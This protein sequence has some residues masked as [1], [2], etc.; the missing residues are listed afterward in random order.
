MFLFQ[1]KGGFSVW[2]EKKQCNYS[3]ENA[4]NRA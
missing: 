1:N 4:L 2:F 3:K